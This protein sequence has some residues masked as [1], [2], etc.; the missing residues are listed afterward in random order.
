[1]SEVWTD[2]KPCP[3]CGG[4]TTWFDT[5][6]FN[7]SCEEVRGR[8]LPLSGTPIEYVRCER[9]AFCFAPEMY[10][11]KLEDFA[12]RVYN[13]DY[14][15]VDPDYRDARPRGN[16]GMLARTFQAVEAGIRHLDYGGGNGLL[17]GILHDQGWQSTSYDPFVNREVDPRD[18][19][20]FDLVTAFEV[21]EHVPNPEKLMA[22]M[23]AL[24]DEDG[25][26][27]FSTL[28]TDGNVVPGHPLN[29]W[30]ASPRNG[31]ISLYSRESLAI[32]GAANGLNLASFSENL[33]AY[34]RRVPAW[35]RH[36]FPLQAQ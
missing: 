14:A 30:Y 26:L 12:S 24:I 3:V 28:I 2:P 6:D 9:C 8:Y 32:L 17:S 27:L 7:K 19:G 22:D 34:W 25:V 10:E 29:W 35:A 16:A 1:M 18:L 23:A 20:R 4:T 5:V 11:W 13:A 15:E 31:H 36:I 21:F 33:H